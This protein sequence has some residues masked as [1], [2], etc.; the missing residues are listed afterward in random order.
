MV[1]KILAIAALTLFG[2]AA[3]AQQGGNQISNADIVKMLKAGVEQNTVKWVIDNSTGKLDAAPAALQKLKAAGASQTIL[4]AVTSK[5]TIAHHAAAAAHAP[6]TAKHS[7]KI[8][9]GASAGSL[10]TNPATASSF[11]KKVESLQGETCEDNLQTV[12]DCHASHKTGCTQSANPRYDAYLNYLKNGLPDPTSTASSSVSGGSALDANFFASL[13]SAIPDT[14]TSTNHAQHAT[15]LAQQGEGQIVTLIG[16]VFYTLHGGSE[17]CNCQLSGDESV[18]D[19]HIGVGF[20]AFPLSDSVLNQLRGGTEY[21]AILSPADQHL[22]DQPS[23][24][25]EM[26]PYYREQFHPAWTLAKVQSV[27]G[28]QVKVTGQLMIDNV[29]HI[30]KDDCGLGD[31][32]TSKCWRAS[33][34]E[35]HPVTNFQVCS[36]D[37]CDASSTNWVNLDEM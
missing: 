36:V 8:Q 11:A 4:D 15:D 23:V 35:V 31:A 26:T 28:K 10:L 12:D 24:V 32:D 25:V 33:T 1:H 9:H 22:L 2:M 34:W 18:V 21:S 19:F 37:H 17:T 5:S 14:L 29:H 16:T 6:K 13:E 30:P 3:M 27:T 20:G 7:T